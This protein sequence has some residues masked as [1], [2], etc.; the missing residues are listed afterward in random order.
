M[1]R[2]DSALFTA[3]ALCGALL[4]IAY[5]AELDYDNKITT[6][7]SLSTTQGY[8]L[9]DYSPMK[10]ALVDTERYARLLASLD[11]E[12]PILFFNFWIL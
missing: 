8:N 1:L 2:L 7:C 12:H 11:W 5:G 10:L 3:A 9:K 6:I 4:S